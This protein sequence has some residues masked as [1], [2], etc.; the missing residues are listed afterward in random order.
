MKKIYVDLDDTLVTSEIDPWRGTVRRI[1]PR[2]DAADF[3]NSLSLYG[4]VTILTRAEVGHA[5]DALRKLG[6]AESLV[7]D[8]VTLEDLQPVEDQVQAI[9]EAPISNTRK[10]A[11]LGRIRPILPRGWIF[12]DQPV[13]SDSY[14]VKSKAT[15]SYEYDW[16]RVEP[17]TLD[18]PDARGLRKAFLAFEERLKQ[19][20]LGRMH[21]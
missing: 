7:H 16:I 2:R 6:D 5:E 11:L 1:Y 17:F 21:A 14:Y 18:H 4:P 15:G 12:D 8:V 3:L 20:A 13:A 9:M 19:P 10:L